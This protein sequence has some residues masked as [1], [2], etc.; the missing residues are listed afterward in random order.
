[1]VLLILYFLIN[2]LIENKQ[3]TGLLLVVF[4]SGFYMMERLFYLTV[5]ISALIIFTGWLVLRILKK[6][7]TAAIFLFFTYNFIYT[8]A[9]RQ[10]TGSITLSFRQLGGVSKHIK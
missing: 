3:T 8:D 4:V 10:C 2:R 5:F 1:M 7:L 9:N 6:G